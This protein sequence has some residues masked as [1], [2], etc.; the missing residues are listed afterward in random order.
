MWDGSVHGY[1]CGIQVFMDVYVGCECS[2][3]CMWDVSVH[4]CVC[5]MGV[6]MDV[7]VG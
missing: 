2:W 4:G 6:S 1:V 3:M 7:C 5:G